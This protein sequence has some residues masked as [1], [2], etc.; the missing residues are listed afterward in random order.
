MELQI[1][2]TT[3]NVHKVNAYQWQKNPIVFPAA[4]LQALM[5]CTSPSANYGGIGVV[6]AHEIT[7]IP[8]ALPLKMAVLILVDVT[9]AST[10]T[11]KSVIDQFEGQDSSM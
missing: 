4:I 7:S 10:P 6:I 9:I 3:R 5:T 1:S 8:M 2:G 11:S